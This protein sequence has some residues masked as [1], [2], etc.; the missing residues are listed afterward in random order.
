MHL[1]LRARLRL[2]LAVIAATLAILSLAAIVS[3]DRLGG[4]IATILKE[5]YVSVVAC[6]EMN[7]ALERQDSAAIFAAAGREDVARGLLERHRAA[8]SKAFAV[9]AANVT[10]PGEGEQV[11]RVRREYDAYVREVD[12]VLALPTADRTP[13]Y[14][15]SLLP[16][17][18]SLKDALH[19]I[20]AMNQTN[21]EEADRGA[22]HLAVRTVRVAIGISIALVLFA[23][24]FA[25]WLPRALVGPV[26]Q[27]SRT[28]RA[29][30]EGDL[31]LEVPRFPIAE[32]EPL[33]QAFDR[34]LVKLRTYRAS[35]LGELLA[36]KD[37][38]NAT[39]ACM[40]DPVVV[41]GA[42]GEILLANEA[43][44]RAF[45]LQPGTAEELR[46]LEIEVP[47]GIAAA[48]DAV[49]RRGVAVLPQTLGEAMRTGEGERERFYLVRATALEPTGVVVLAQDV[50]RYR[51]IDELKSD[52]VATVSHQFKT[53]LTSLRM[54]THMLLEPS[55]GTLTEGQKELVVTARDET[56]RLRTMVDELLDLVRI[57]AQA[58]QL[59]RRPIDVGSLLSEVSDAHRAVARAKNVAVQVA[60]P[61]PPV[62]VEADPDRIAIVLA[63]LVAN[64]IQHTREGGQITLSG[65]SADGSIEI[66]VTDTGEGIEAADLDRI[67]D[68]AVSLGPGSDGRERHGLG[69][70]IAREIVLQ[71]G[72]DLAVESTI[73]KGSRFTIRLPRDLPPAG[74]FVSASA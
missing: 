28:A 51:R 23:A 19:R 9:E 4:A 62:T 44:E 65:G 71:H 29:I 15:A 5:N 56:E 64:A 73:G 14:F 42:K 7:E 10:L 53:P 3:L 22:K 67:F 37:L 45:R 2:G 13:Q 59:Q 58:G 68:R 48:R 54:A 36:A 26:E 70:T 61:V 12:R 74:I 1:S 6:G 34:M 69:L 18:E 60:A 21:M 20:Q 30:G 25:W 33:T 57:E 50:T 31:D 35:S 17:F 66:A 16:K 47:E 72:G 43:A 8:F 11:E 41:F 49:L 38:A 24:W 46:A 63:N 55:V 52:V 32:L 39:V 27:L 40:L